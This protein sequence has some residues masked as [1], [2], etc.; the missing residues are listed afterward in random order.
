M[1][2]LKKLEALLSQGK[3]SRR[4]FLSRMSALGLAVAAS[5]LVNVGT[6]F[7]DTPKKGGH[8]ILGMGHGST[9]DSLDPAI[10][11]NFFA[12][13]FLMSRH[14]HIA[15]VNPEGKLIPELAESWEATPDA[16]TW[17]FKVRRGVEF[18]N[19][20]TLEAKD[21][22]NSINHHR[23]EDS[24]SPA[25]TLL[26]SVTDIKTDGKY[27]FTIVLNGGNAGFPYIISDY[28]I[29]IMPT[30]DGKPDWKS[31]IGTGGYK[32]DS[33]EPGVSARLSRFPNYWKAPNRAHFDSIEMLTIA[34]TAT[35]TNAL[36]TGS[37]HAMDRCDLKTV[38]LLKKMPGLRI[39]DVTGT[40]HYTMPMH[41][42]QAPF[43]N[44]DVRLALKLAI[45]RE[46]ILK[47]V[48]R[49]YGI[50]GNDHPISPANEFHAGELPQ[51]AY[52]PEK[53]RYHVKKSGVGTLKVKLHTAE[54]AF[55]GA[56]D[57]AV[58]CKEYASK[59]G[60]DI[61]VVR[62]PDD[63]YWSN[64]WTKVGWCMCYWGGRPTEDWMFSTAYAADAAWNDAHWEH[65]RFNKLLIEGR[66]ELDSKK[67]REIYVEMQRIVRDEG[68][69]VVPLFNNYVFACKDKVQH[70]P[71]IAGN[72]DMD[73]MKI[74]E[75]WWFA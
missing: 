58:L 64:T 19:G 22:V 62:A 21:F 56:T 74:N 4:D 43:D 51:R 54:A 75:R 30:K 48:L 17:H 9:T 67:R 50:V 18:Q 14:N 5:P 33:Y 13:T 59:A 16:K 26:K 37:I 45:D 10:T 42:K 52:D 29:P 34:D 73:G 27:A 55:A 61:Q 2:E 39:E 47:T 72:W 31:G 6:V 49:G 63:G 11:E 71:H 12:Q 68:G 32:I 35:R 36:K 24:K 20:Q 7:A 44:N 38:H 23:S 28:H 53:A 70:G 60:I 41:T 3:I 57:A 69:T 1:K 15:E 46:A 65:E 66:A 40:A 8:F 25:K